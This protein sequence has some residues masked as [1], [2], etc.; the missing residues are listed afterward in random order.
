ML[1]HMG[2]HQELLFNKALCFLSNQMKI[3]MGRMR[4]KKNISEVAAK[5]AFE[6]TSIIS[7]SKTKQI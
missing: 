4:K 5:H 7:V 2:R 1:K 6:M 3:L